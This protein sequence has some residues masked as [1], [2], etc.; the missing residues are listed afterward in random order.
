[1]RTIMVMNAKGGCG[2]TTIATNI[3][4]HFANEGAAVALADFDPLGSSLDWLAARPPERVGIQGI[5]AVNEGL[6]AVHRGLDVLVIDSPARSHGAELTDLTRRAETIVIPVLPSPVDINAVK[7]FTSEL[8][9]VGRVSRGEVKVAVV[10]NRINEQTLIWNDLE[11][12]LTRLRMPFIGR[13]RE[14]QN[15]IRAFSRGLSIFELPPYLAW[16]DW[17]QWEPVTGWLESK[18]SMP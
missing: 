11:Q 6:K 17:E 18:R 2:K 16:P 5:D 15:Y 12:F 13:L 8:S 9:E 1:M 3:A 14:A 7:R 10:A 4:A